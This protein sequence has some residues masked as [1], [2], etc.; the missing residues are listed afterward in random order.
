MPAHGTHGQVEELVRAQRPVR[1]RRTPREIVWRRH[2]RGHCSSDGPRSVAA[3]ANLEEARNEHIRGHAPNSGSARFVVPASSGHD[4]L[5]GWTGDSDRPDRYRSL[6]RRCDCPCTGDTLDGHSI[7]AGPARQHGCRARRSD[8]LGQFEP[9][10]HR[11]AG[12]AVRG[13]NGAPYAGGGPN[14]GLASVPPAASGHV[15]PPPRNADTVTGSTPNGV[16]AAARCSP[17]T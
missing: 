17:T 14:S 15:R 6:G 11:S 4:R 1:Q 2:P 10:Q 12:G 8:H 16:A 7:D 3:F 9:V 13:F 5:R